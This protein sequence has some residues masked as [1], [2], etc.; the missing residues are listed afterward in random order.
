MSEKPT[1]EEL[2]HRVRELEIRHRQAENELRTSKVDLA[3]AQRI[4]RLGNWRMEIASGAV[5]WSAEP[6]DLVRIFEIE[7]KGPT[8]L[9]RSFIGRVLPE[10]RAL[11]EET[12]RKA[13]QDGLPFTLEFRI[14]T[15]T[16]GIKH[17]RETG[18]GKKN[19]EGDVVT[20][21]GIAQD[22]TEIVLS[23]S[24]LEVSEARLDAV[25][26]PLAEGVVI[27]DAA[28]VVTEINRAVTD[29][30]GHTLEEL[31]DQQ[32]GPCHRLICPDGTPF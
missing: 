22:I 10:D 30:F 31:T 2:E 32:E 25:L 19:S 6:V 8:D 7:K 21:L 12:D 1:Y 11:V 13:R 26:D 27:L 9:Y 28:G 16:G 15:P 5:S 14:Q 17:I 20:L 24:V 29:T 4:T 18:Y 23:R 3:E